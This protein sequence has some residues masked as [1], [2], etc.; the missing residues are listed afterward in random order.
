MSSAPFTLGFS[1]VIVTSLD[2]GIDSIITIPAGR[3]WKIE[4]AGIGG[5]NGVIYLKKNATDKIAILFSS[6]GNDDYSSPLP[7]WL[8]EKLMRIFTRDFPLHLN[9]RAQQE[10]LLL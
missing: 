3:I 1:Q 6:I 9:L 2:Q 7:F 4:S 8:A 5:T 10:I